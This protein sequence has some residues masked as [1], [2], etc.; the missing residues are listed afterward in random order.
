MLY[1]NVKQCFILGVNKCV[2]NKAVRPRAQNH[3]DLIEI[4][5]KYTL[6]YYVGFFNLRLIR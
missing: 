6:R 5:S 2:I 1:S 4:K 3:T